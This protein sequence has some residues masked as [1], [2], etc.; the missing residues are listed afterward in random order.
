[1]TFFEIY[2]STLTN[3]NHFLKI[4]TSSTNKNGRKKL[5]LK[6]DYKNT[7][8]FEL[9]SAREKKINI[10]QKLNDKF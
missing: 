3:L 4:K 1:M 7:K 5:Q 2:A 6:M 9:P 8:L 10:Y